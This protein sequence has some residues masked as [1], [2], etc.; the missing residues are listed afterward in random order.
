MLR[1]KNYICKN[2]NYTN[3][4]IRCRILDYLVSN[5]IPIV[6]I[7]YKNSI[8]IITF[9][10]KTDNIIKNTLVKKIIQISK[11]NRL[12]I[13]DIIEE[14]KNVISYICEMQNIIQYNYENMI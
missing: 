11:Y 3:I 14:N 12:E 5:L 6:C 9:K 8:L 2:T 4:T 7:S 10:E 13:I 1:H